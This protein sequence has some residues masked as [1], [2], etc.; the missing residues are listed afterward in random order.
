MYVSPILVE[1]GNGSYSL[2]AGI[3]LEPHDHVHL[4]IDLIMNL[5]FLGMNKEGA[6][7]RVHEVYGDLIAEGFGSYPAI[8]ISYKSMYTIKGNYENSVYL[9]S[10]LGLKYVTRY[11]VV[12][13]YY[14]YSSSQ[15]VESGTYESSK[16]ILPLSFYVGFKSPTTDFF[17]D[18]Y[19][20]LGIN[21][22]SGNEWNNPLENEGFSNAR[23][24]GASVIFG[25]TFCFG[26]S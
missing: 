4:T 9:A 11:F 19:L 6:Y 22:F 8:G 23:F 25:Y 7:I 12:D 17:H 5:Q 24:L 20:G 3:A 21:F 13:D 14:S 2:G 16:F 15:T 1:E 18:V 26:R 10:G